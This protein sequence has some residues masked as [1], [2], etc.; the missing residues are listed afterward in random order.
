MIE[1]Y[2]WEC[3]EWTTV[4]L[5]QSENGWEER[6]ASTNCVYTIRTM[7]TFGESIF[8]ITLDLSVFDESGGCGFGVFFYFVFR[9][10]NKGT[11]QV[12]LSKA[13]YRWPLNVPS[14]E[15]DKKSC[16]ETIHG[17]TNE[18]REKETF[19]NIAPKSCLFPRMHKIYFHCFPLF[20]PIT[21]TPK[22]LVFD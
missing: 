15:S 11:N 10:P 18:N 1:W 4:N 3:N 13:L 12:P 6:N 5:K 7:Q 21:L 20:V 8:E 16:V 2:S 22:Y 17:N 9:K 14:H 19:I